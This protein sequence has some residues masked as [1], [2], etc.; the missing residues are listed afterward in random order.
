VSWA[1]SGKLDYWSNAASK[2]TFFNI[3]PDVGNRP[4]LVIFDMDSSGP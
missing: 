4:Y 3:K 2:A 1:G